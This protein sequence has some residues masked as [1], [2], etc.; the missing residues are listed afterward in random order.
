MPPPVTYSLFAARF[1]TRLRAIKQERKVKETK[2]LEA[3]IEAL[4][5]TQQRE[6]G[7]RPWRGAYRDRR[8]KKLENGGGRECSE[9]SFDGDWS[10]RDYVV[11]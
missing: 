6:N 2:D 11:E 8:V 5:R 1:S 10:K 3:R 7:V 9:C 4:E